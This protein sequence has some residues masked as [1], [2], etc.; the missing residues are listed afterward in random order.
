MIRRIPALLLVVGAVL[1]VA[2]TGASAIWYDEA[3]MIY[4]SSIP[5]L[6]LFRETSENSGDLLLE[7]ILRP[8]LAISHSIWVLRLPSIIAGLISLWLVWILMQRLAFTFKQQIVAAAIVA[9]LPGLIWIA[10]DARTYGILAC[11]FLAAILFAIQGR[12]LGLFATCGLM[13]YTH[14]VG[15]AF[16]LAA[17]VIADYLHPKETRWI[18]LVGT[19]TALAWIPAIVNMLN[20]WIIQQPWQPHLTLAWG[21]YSTIRAIWPMNYTEWFYLL[22]A[23]LLIRT[24][25]FLFSKGRNDGR[26]IPLLAWSIPIFGLIAFSLI[27]RNNI[28]MY[29]TIMPALLPFAMWLGWEMGR[30]KIPA[31]SWVLVL[32]LG[33]TMW[34]PADRGGRLDIVAEEIRSQ[35]RTGDRLVYTTVTVGIPFNYYLGDL[36][37]AWDDTVHSGFLLIPTY[38]RTNLDPP[39]GAPI[40]SWVV[41][42]EDG[43]ITP[44]EKAILMDLV[45]HQKPV[46]TVAYMQAA[47]IYVYLIEER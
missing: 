7:L 37:H 5:F 1:R 29:R 21:V 43:L 20:H 18:L 42:P 17:L 44:G 11:L 47:T 23:F 13:F 27:T 41:I 14:K 39:T 35:W 9:F 15:P 45:H 3:N 6:T 30:Q 4:R 25:F 28:F 10:Q 36:P 34:N 40:R 38:S 32:V 31:L 8:L 16:A 46:Y 12:W 19:G 24:L 22:A 26:I 2:W 33:M